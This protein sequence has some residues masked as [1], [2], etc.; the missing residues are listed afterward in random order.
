MAG[1]LVVGSWFLWCE[2]IVRTVVLVLLLVMVPVVVPLSIFPSLRR[3]GWRLAET[4]CAVAAS[5]FVIVVTLAIGLNEL[6]GSS[7]VEVLAG[8][9]TLALATCTPFLILRLMPVLEQSAL[10]GA[11]GI[12]ARATRA[13]GSL[14]S[15][16]IAGAVR[17]LTPDADLGGAPTRPDHLGLDS[18]PG[19][20]E[21]PLAPTDGD[22]PPPPVGTPRVRGGHVVYRS[23]EGGPVVGWHFDE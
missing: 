8:A 16:P 11:E 19:E 22:T 21:T 20:G 15:S 5:K 2:L 7:R 10:H 13:I 23:D 17:S 18:W 4:F 1:A 3:I 9:L 12:R 14:S 6:D